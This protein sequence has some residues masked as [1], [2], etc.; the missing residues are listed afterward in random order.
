M[1]YE[2]DALDF[3]ALMDSPDCL[4][5]IDPPYHHGTRS[6]YRYKVEFGPERH[7]AL[8]ARLLAAK[9]K[10]VLSG[11]DCAEYRPLELAGWK[12]VSW[13]SR[14]NMSRTTREECLWIKA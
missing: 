13:K 8:V 6:A 1:I 5:Y 14:A 2:R 3:F 7:V 12:K 4:Q 11:Y 10:V 9:C